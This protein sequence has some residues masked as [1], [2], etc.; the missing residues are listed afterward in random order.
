MRRIL[1]EDHG[2]HIVSAKHG[3]SP[4]GVN[5]TPEHG[6]T[7]NLGEVRRV[8]NDISRLLREDPSTPVYLRREIQFKGTSQR[9]SV[10]LISWGRESADSLQQV[11]IENPVSFET[12][13][14][15]GGLKG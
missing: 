9:G 1:P 13:T 4:F 2:G 8:E 7:V 11:I 15:A 6:R 3:G 14:R 12:S 10:F 5:L